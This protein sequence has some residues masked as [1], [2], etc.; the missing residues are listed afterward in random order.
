[1]QAGGVLGSASYRFR[2]SASVVRPA[3]GDVAHGTDRPAT[4]AE[5]L[6]Q[7]SYRVSLL[8]VPPWC[9]A[10][11]GSPPRAGHWI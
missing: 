11:A 3:T 2:A 7:G 6:D 5:V 8:G 1:M 9:P 10:V 4:I